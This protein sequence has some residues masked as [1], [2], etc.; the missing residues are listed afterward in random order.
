[1]YFIGILSFFGV[2]TGIAIAYYITW[3]AV[4]WALTPDPQ[5]CPERDNLARR[6]V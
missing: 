4:G 1:M 5:N 3:Q 2:V 6:R